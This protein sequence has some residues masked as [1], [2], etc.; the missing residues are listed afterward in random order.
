MRARV[1]GLLGL[2]LIFGLA[3]G[4]TDPEP[5][6]SPPVSPEPTEQPVSPEPTEPPAAQTVQI[7]LH[8]GNSEDCAEVVAV[9]REVGGSPTLTTGMEQL[10]A[11]PTD[12]EAADGLG[13]WFTDATSD[14]L[15]SAELDGEVARVDFEDFRDVIPNASS[16]CGSAMLLAQLDETAEGF[17]ATSTLYSIEGDTNTF[18]EWLQLA[19]PEA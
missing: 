7:Y 17:G 1:R 10:L 14:M 8:S 11:G 18:Y 3:C 2:C 5:S 6:P 4:T 15:I 16:S 12:A 19:T 13:G 9:T